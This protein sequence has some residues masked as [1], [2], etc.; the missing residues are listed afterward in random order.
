MP[1][2]VEMPLQERD[3]TLAEAGELLA[4]ARAGSGRLLVLEGPAGIG[5]TRLLASIHE[6][7]RADGM[8]TL[9]ARAGELEQDFPF[10]V[11]RQL[12]DAA[13]AGPARAERLSG[14]AELAGKLFDV[15]AEEGTGTPHARPGISQA[16]R[17]CVA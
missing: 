1:L 16:G 15:P 12:F 13:L 17:G 3:D 14:A 5:K 2:T 6:R 8:Q 10:G 9:R 7:A 11:V 4:E